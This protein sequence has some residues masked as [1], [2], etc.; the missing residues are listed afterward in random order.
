MENRHGSGTV[1][2]IES[3]ETM[4]HFIELRNRVRSGLYEVP[5]RAVAEAFLR[6]IKQPDADLL[7]GWGELGQ[8]GGAN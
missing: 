7:E 5:A 1:L 4:E 3:G 8:V 6:R 2:A